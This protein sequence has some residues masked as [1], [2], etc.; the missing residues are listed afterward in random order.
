[1][2]SFFSMA[3]LALGLIGIAAAIVGWAV[4]ILQD[5]WLDDLEA[6]LAAAPR[7]AAQ[8]PGEAAPERD[9]AEEATGD[10]DALGDADA[11]LAQL[12]ADL[13]A[14]K[15]ELTALES[16][17]AESAAELGRLET[18]IAAMRAGPGDPAAA[19]RTRTRARIRAEPSTDAAEVALVSA[20]QQVG[21]SGAKED[22]SWYRVTVSGYMFRELLQ[23]SSEQ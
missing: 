13:R 22:E 14:G 20:D 6:R 3:K 8:S 10:Q 21:V 2:T 18:E 23:P 19:Y 11:N 1:M 9:G 4:V 15:Q 5:R 17:I 12:E 16:E 7:E